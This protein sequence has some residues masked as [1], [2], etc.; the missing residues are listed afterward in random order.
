MDGNCIELHLY[1]KN[2]CIIQDLYIPSSAS[3][4]NLANYNT[5]VATLFLSAVL[6][7]GQSLLTSTNNSCAIYIPSSQ[8]FPL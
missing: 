5:Q 7:S 4:Y 6:H 1:T 2:N 3:T 8:N